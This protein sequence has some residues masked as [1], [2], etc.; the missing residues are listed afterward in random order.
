MRRFVTRRRDGNHAEIQAAMIQAGA[1]VYDA[2]RHGTPF[3]LIVFWRS[4]T[5]LVEIK[6]PDA[7]RGATEARKLTAD[8]QFIHR[9]ANVHGCTI[10]VV[11]TVEQ[12]LELLGAR[13][14]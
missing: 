2:A 4:R 10:H 9:M 5:L 6:N 12:A 14:G 1:G 13:L 7:A 8:E 3:D 11:E